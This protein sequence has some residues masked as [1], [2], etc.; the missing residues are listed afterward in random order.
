MMTVQEFG[1]KIQ[2]L[3]EGKS[4]NFDE[5]YAMFC[6]LMT[7]SQPDLQQGAFLA[8]LVA[9]G[10]TVE[11]IA[12]AWA[13]IDEFDTVHLEAELPELLCEN[14]GTGMDQLKTFNVSSAAAIIAASCGMPMARHG[15]R[16]ITSSCGTVDIMEAVGVDVNCPVATVGE[17][18]RAAG[19]GLFNGMS[20]HV[21]PGSLGRILSQIR[22]GSTLNIAASLANPCRPSHGL[23]GVYSP[24]LVSKTAEVMRRIGY[25]RGLVVH[26]MDDATGLGMDEISVCG[27]TE[28][29]EF[30]AS[31]TVRYDLHPADFGIRQVSVSEIATTGRI[32]TETGRFMD[33]LK[34]NGKHKACEDFACFNAGAVLYLT[35]HAPEISGGIDSAREA[36]ATGRAM[37]KLREWIT[38]QDSTGGRGVER[39]DSLVSACAG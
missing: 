14:S 10:E 5:T 12:G 13:A 31:G 8:A 29:C 15:A 9:K 33:V 38:C 23:R 28:V 4:L 1:A 39:F 6:E 7:D 11:E 16:G 36:V 22:F 34:G 19:I 24:G 17:S 21:H 20:P 30:T 25:R 27:K 35:G 18:I 37:G 2:R 3:I 26:G 32:E